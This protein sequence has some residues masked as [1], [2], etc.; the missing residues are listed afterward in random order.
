MGFS[1]SLDTLRFDTSVVMFSC[2]MDS[3]HE[4]LVAGF[5][6]WEHAVET[7]PLCFYVFV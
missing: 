7:S 5:I 6:C 3:F 4:E 2:A 1:R